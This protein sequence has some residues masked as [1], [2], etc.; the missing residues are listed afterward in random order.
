MLFFSFHSDLCNLRAVGKRPAVAGN[1]GLVG[2]DHYRICHHRFKQFI[3]LTDGDNL[4]VFVSFEV[5][6]RQ[7]IWKLQCVLVLRRKDQ[8]AR[9]GDQYRERERR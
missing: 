3:S 8:R 9:D 4:P 2:V 1:T 6:E 5:R 7:T